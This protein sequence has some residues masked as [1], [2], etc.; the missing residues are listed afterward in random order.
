MRS[1]TRAEARRACRGRAAGVGARERGAQRLQLRRSWC[2]RTGARAARRGPAKDQDD[3]RARRSPPPRAAAA[4][5]ARTAS[6]ATASSVG[7]TRCGC[8]LVARRARTRSRI[9]TPSGCSAGRR[10]PARSSLRRR[11][12]CTS[13]ARSNTSW[14]RPRASIISFSRASGWRG[15]CASTLSRRNSPVVSVTALAVA[16]QRARREIERV[17]AEGDRAVRR[18]RA[19]RE[20]LGLPAQHGVDARDQLARIERLG[21]VIVGAHLQADDAIDVLALGGEHDDRHRLAGAAQAAAYRQAVLAGQHQVEHE[22]V[23][24][25]ALQL[26]CRGR[27]RRAAP[28]PGS[29]ARRDSASSRSRRRTSSS[30]TR[31]RCEASACP[32][33]IGTR[34]Q[35]HGDA[36]SRNRL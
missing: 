29:P 28:A 33:S 1:R 4:R 35:V 23:R 17:R 3:R 22:Q 15:C 18:R 20:T 12:T 14:S 13:I 11:D 10:D 27:V 32:C 5:A 30:T 26:A 7:W 24:R 9:P 2:R 25:I 36:A 21:E 6:A 16:R 31:M 8:S 19:G 34:R